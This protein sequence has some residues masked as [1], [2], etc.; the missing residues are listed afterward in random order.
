MLT[1]TELGKRLNLSAR[2][3]N[4][5]LELAGFQS[6]YRDDKDRLHWALTEVGRKYAIY[7]DSGRKQANGN[8]VRQIK[9][10]SETVNQLKIV[11]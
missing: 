5:L 1:P 10:Y 7:L 11:W 3:T 9:W 6:S 8:P 4:A 2:R